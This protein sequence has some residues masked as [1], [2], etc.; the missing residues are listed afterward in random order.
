M[1]QEVCF[2][3]KKVELFL[4]F[5]FVPQAAWLTVVLWAI[6]AGMGTVETLG[7]TNT[8]KLKEF[9][10]WSGSSLTRLLP[11]LANNV[12]PWGRSHQ[13]ESFLLGAAGQELDEGPGEAADPSPGEASTALVVQDLEKEIRDGVSNSI[14][15]FFSCSRNK[16]EAAGS[17]PWHGEMNFLLPSVK[18]HSRLTLTSPCN[19]F[20]TSL[21][22][23]G[24]HSGQG[25]ILKI[26]YSS[27]SSLTRKYCFL[28][29]LLHLLQNNVFFGIL[30]SVYFLKLLKVWV[31]W[32]GIVPWCKQQQW[33]SLHDQES[34]LGEEQCHKS[35]QCHQDVWACILPL[36]VFFCPSSCAASTTLYALQR[37]YSDFRLHS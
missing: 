15:L 22:C 10:L 6:P 20:L 1:C 7:S 5:C 21:A 11:L 35:G 32:Y 37:R 4:A 28:W 12:R 2:L 24:K 30:S 13:E 29:N 18:H 9:L 25:E 36:A 16:I 26:F 31:T 34:V 17:L 8:L 23:H 14:R 27:Y 3:W 19:S 33:V